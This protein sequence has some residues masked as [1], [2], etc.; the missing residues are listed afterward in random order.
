MKALSPILEKTAPGIVHAMLATSFSITPYAAMAR[1][2][3]G[4]RGG[5]IVIAVPGSPKA[6][7]ENLEA[8]IK[9]LPHACDLA[10]GGN[11]RAMHAERHVAESGKS[12]MD[13]KLRVH[14]SL[15]PKEKHEHGHHHHSHGHGH[16]GVKAHTTEEQRALLS[17]ELGGKG[18]S[19][20]LSI[21]DSHSTTSFISIP[22][23]LR[24]R[25][26]P[27]NHI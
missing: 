21:N 17:N 18:M 25:R 4:V 5:T 14:S 20:H 8:V 13:D 7:K 1:P 27:E 22:N 23:A 16:A 9:L 10:C 3:A 15:P 12:V 19:Y 6:A 24:P 2:V 11:S 26:N